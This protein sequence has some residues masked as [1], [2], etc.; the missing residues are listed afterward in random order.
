MRRRKT[1]ATVWA[2]LL[3]YCILFTPLEKPDITERSI[4]VSRYQ[5]EPNSITHIRLII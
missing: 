3:F 1:F 4:T 2:L 5:V